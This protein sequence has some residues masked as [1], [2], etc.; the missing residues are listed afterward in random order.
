MKRYIQTFIFQIVLIF[1]LN[2]YLH[3]GIS[4]EM[5]L[6]SRSYSLGQVATISYSDILNSIN[7]P[8]CLSNEDKYSFSLY[9]SEPFEDSKNASTGFC[10]P[11]EYYGTFG[12]SYYYFILDNIISRDVNQNNSNILSWSQKQFVISWANQIYDLISYGINAKWLLDSFFNENTSYMRTDHIGIDFSF[13]IFPNIN[14]T[15]FKNLGICF[16]FKNLIQLND[17]NEYLPKEFRFIIEK[18]AR[19]DS[20]SLFFIFNYSRYEI[21]KNNYHSNL[22]FGLEYGYKFLFIR[23]GHNNNLSYKN[24]NFSL[25]I[26]IKF[27]ILKLDY[28]YGNYLY[29]GDFNQPVHNITLSVEI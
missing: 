8:S 20:N 22:H 7:N 14:I 21:Y 17:D 3:A 29:Y 25:G 1:I 2:C 19:F 6:G 27:K 5:A 23:V 24:D 26:G 16:T 11:T 18:S 15:G 10:I 13:S 12:F 9:Y 28:G 4:P